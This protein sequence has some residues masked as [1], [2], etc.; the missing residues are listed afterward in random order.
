MN[1][2]PLVSVIM[3]VYNEIPEY[4][5][6]AVESIL[7]QTYENIEFLIAD[8]GSTPEMAVA[9]DAAA[10]LDPRIHLIR[11]ENLGL[12][13]SL[14]H[15]IRQ[16]HGAFV[17]RQDSDDISEPD[18]IRQQVS[19]FADRPKLM[20]L[21]TGCLLIDAQGKVLHRQRVKTRPRTLKRLLRHTNQFVHGSVMFRTD[22]F[23]Y[24][25]Y[26]EDFRYAEDYD[27]FARIA[28]RFPVANINLPLYRY[29]INP[30]S[31]SVSKS[32][33]Q[34][35]M[36]MIVREAARLRSK[37]NSIHWSPE[38]FE[39]I[40]NTLK[41]PLHRR[42]LECLVFGAQGRINN[43]AGRKAEA[44]RMYWRAF[45]SYPSPQALWWLLRSLIPWR[46]VW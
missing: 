46:Y 29:R 37:G 2:R 33:E 9:L 6:L 1:A 32:R 17:G 18:R 10:R 30:E 27:L 7:H 20:L 25:M 11:H 13:E 39:L 26:Y 24:H 16:T 14:N 36:G 34:L 38:T 22:V 43:L 5:N 44:R 15:L 40:S 41:T 8:D 3:S 31:I 12:T 19:F 21:G 28:D 45:A 35:F 4:L 42:H 23:N